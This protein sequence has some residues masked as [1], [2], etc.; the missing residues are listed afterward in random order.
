MRDIPGMGKY[1]LL[2]LPPDRGI[3]AISGDTL[4]AV[5]TA[6]TAGSSLAYELQIDGRTRFRMSRLRSDSPYWVVVSEETKPQGTA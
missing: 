2:P 1:R 5:T 4:A 6:A 3:P